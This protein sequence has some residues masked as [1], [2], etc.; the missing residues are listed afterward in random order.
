MSAKKMRKLEKARERAR[1]KMEDEVR[2]KKIDQALDEI[3][4]KGKCYRTAAR[5]YGLHEATLR[6]RA[7]L[8]RAGRRGRDAGKT[9]KFTVAQEQML[10]EHCIFMSRLG[11]GLTYWQI[12]DIAENMALMQGSTPPSTSWFYQGFL[13]RHPECKMLYPTS[14]GKARDNV[15]QETIDA[16]FK[17]LGTVLQDLNLKNCPDRIWN[18]DETGVSLDHKTPKVLGL[19]KE[20]SHF[21]SAGRSPTT[22]MIS[23]VNASG[24][25][26]PPYLICKGKIVTPDMR[27]GADPGTVFASSANGW[28]NSI[29]FKDWFLNHFCRH[30]DTSKPVILFYDGHTTHYSSCII[31]A[32]RERGVHLFVLPPHSSHLLQPL[33]VCGFGHFKR[34]LYTGIHKWMAQN[35][36][37]VM[38]RDCLPTLMKTAWKASMID[39][40]IIMSFVKTGICP[41]N[42]NAVKVAVP[43]PT[44]K[45]KGKSRKERKVLRDCKM[46]F[47]GKVLPYLSRPEPVKKRASL[48]PEHGCLITT[49]EKEQERE[50]MEEV[51]RAKKAAAVQD[52]P[53]IPPFTRVDIHGEVHTEAGSATRKRKA[54]GKKPGK[55]TEEVQDGV[56]KKAKKTVKGL[57]KTENEMQDE[58]MRKKKTVRGLAKKGKSSFKTPPPGRIFQLTQLEDS[59]EPASALDD[60]AFYV[61]ERIGGAGCSRDEPQV[62]SYDSDMTATA[63]ETDDQNCAICGRFYSDLDIEDNWVQCSTCL[64]WVHVEAC[65]NMT[66]A[67]LPADDDPFE[68]PLCEHSF[69]QEQ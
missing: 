66:T 62:D 50:A 55:K 12:M 44:F 54:A 63:T 1:K 41:Y 19:A 2:E 15:T 46:L 32:A 42:P 38:T 68:C 30:A 10:K 61:A 36:L 8:A 7:K 49:D 29:I 52:A 3:L 13:V 22:T 33:D 48:I 67:D 6:Y 4:E 28:S 35:P 25:T 45:Q 37:K 27:R 64:Y 57:K 58:D 69:S 40:T 9:F 11:Y 24:H 47:E 5:E 59:E 18:M 31:R 60:A 21:V 26:L 17:E 14:R 53:Y 65:C 23:C 56:E 20:K 16:Y 51:S 43:D 34:Q 39:T